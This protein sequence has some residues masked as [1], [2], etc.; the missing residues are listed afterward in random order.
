[1]MTITNQKVSL[2]GISATVLFNIVVLS[3]FNALFTGSAYSFLYLSIVPGFFIWRLLRIQGISFFDSIVFIAG[4]SISY[5]LIVGI[6]TNLLVFLPQMSHPLTM[7]NSL[8][9]FD[10]YTI[11]L[12]LVNHM[13]E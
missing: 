6:S 7:L 13:R 9:V 8:I 1:M 4:F 12:M 10:I 11:P 2:F 3:G 5:L